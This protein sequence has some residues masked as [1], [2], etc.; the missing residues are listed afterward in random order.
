MRR[1]IV[2]LSLKFVAAKHYVGRTY[3]FRQLWNWWPNQL[4]NSNYNSIMAPCNFTL[5]WST[6]PQ[7]I[8]FLS[9]SLR[10]LEFRKEYL[11]SCSTFTLAPFSTNNSDKFWECDCGIHSIIQPCN[12]HCNNYTFLMS[13]MPYNG[14]VLYWQKILDSLMA[15]PDIH[16]QNIVTTGCK[17]VK[18]L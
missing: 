13:L 11:L 3:L 7:A 15:L 12:L 10:W 18:Y 4:S 1:C 8:Y 9:V 2:S 5:I 17:P 6:L 14:S 16:N